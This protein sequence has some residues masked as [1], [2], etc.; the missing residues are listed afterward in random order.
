[1]QAVISRCIL[2]FPVDV[3][4]AAGRGLHSHR[5][6]LLPGSGAAQPPS[7]D[8]VGRNPPVGDQET[9]SGGHPAPRQRV[10]VPAHLCHQPAEAEGN[11]CR[12]WTS[13]RYRRKFS[14]GQ[15]YLLLTRIER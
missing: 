15:N 12:C 1:M 9:V 2:E 4:G 11:P 10:D 7:Q 8:P 6:P 14:S 13:Q 3:P 5:R